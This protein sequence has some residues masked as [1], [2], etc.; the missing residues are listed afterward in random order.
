V[1][2]IGSLTCEDII[3]T[4]GAKNMHVQLIRQ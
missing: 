1:F 2:T 3:K 4:M